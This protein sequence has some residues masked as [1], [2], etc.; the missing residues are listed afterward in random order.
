MKQFFPLWN[1][2]LRLWLLVLGAVAGASLLPGTAQASHIRAG[3]IQARVDTTGVNLARVFF[4]MTLYLDIVGNGSQMPIDE[5]NVTIFFGDGTR[6]IIARDG[7]RRPIPGNTDTSLNF[8]YF[9]HTYPSSGEF[10]VHY[11]GENRNAGVLNMTDSQNQSFY[12]STKF[13]ILP[14]IGFNRSPV[15]SAPAIDRAA[16]SQV[17]LHNPAAS[18]ADGDSLVFR[19]IDC[20]QVPG[21]IGGPASQPIPLTNIPQPVRCTNYRMP[22]DPA[23]TPGAPPVQVAYNGNPAG[24]LGSPAIFV[25]NPRTGQL[26]WN[27]PVRA[28]LYN[29]AF[30]VEEWRRSPGGV[31]QI[32]A[33]I[34]DMQ[35]IVR[36]TNNIRPTLTM[37]LD[38]CVEAGQPVVGRVRLHLASNEVARDDA[39]G[40]AVDHY[41]VQHFGA[42]VHLHFSVGNLAAQ[43]R[44][45]AQQQLLPGLAAGVE[46]AA[47]LGAAEGAVGQQAAVFAGK[48]HA[49]SHALVDD[50]DRHLG[51]AVHVGFAGAVVAALDGVVE[52]TEHGVAVVLVVFSGVDAALRRN[53]VRAAG[54][55][56]VGKGLYVVAQ[57]GQR[58]GGRSAGQAGAYHNDVVL[59]L[60]G[61]V[62]K[63]HVE[64]VLL[65]LLGERAFGNFGIQLHKA[66]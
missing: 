63:L 34:R 4:K 21:G 52:Q 12:I 44:V 45:G 57:L 19:L 64:L 23:V 59:P 53:G 60:V 28:G 47:Y 33:V 9:E 7:G 27:A 55:V 2:A 13:S 46:R 25:I 22:N 62:H 17:F 56:V 50:V 61:G 10:T 39:A 3:D 15:L 5:P 38:I 51:Q 24:M 1:S 54:R 35:I 42:G 48:R 11:V 31:L 41:Q 40:L 65:P 16:V 58:G 8:Y 20:Q 66:T 37:P 30:V 26:T 36:A 6:R 49:L 18:D 32:G 43:G 14:S 29:V